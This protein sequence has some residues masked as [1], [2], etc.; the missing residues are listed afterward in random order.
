MHLDVAKR[1]PLNIEGT[2]I[3]LRRFE[4]NFISKE[5]MFVTEKQIKNNKIKRA[6]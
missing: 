3:A 2:P 4:K 6:L 1:V 5:R